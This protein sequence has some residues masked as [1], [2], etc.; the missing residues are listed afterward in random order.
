MNEMSEPTTILVVDDH[1]VLLRGLCLMLDAEKDM[2]VVGQAQTVDQALELAKSRQPALILLDITLQDSSGLDLI[3]KLQKLAPQTRIVMLTMHENKEYMQQAMARGARGFVLKKGIDQDLLYAVRSV[4]RGDIYIH[5]TLL[6]DYIS[7]STDPEQGAA[8]NG[9][10]DILLWATLSEREQEVLTLV[11]R[12]FTS[13]EIADQ[14]FLSEKTV[15]T[16]RS[17]GMIKL[18][19]SSRSELVQLVLNLGKLTA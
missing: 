16:Y 8:D 7:T 3:E 1:G 2:T 15:A 4:M 11:A 10:N 6:S 5:P 14:C 12:G 19:F 13:K 9:N 17:R 18:A